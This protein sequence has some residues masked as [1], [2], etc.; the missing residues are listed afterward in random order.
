MGLGSES[1]TRWLARAAEPRQSG[2]TSGVGSETRPR[3]STANDLKAALPAGF[4]GEDGRSPHP[5]PLR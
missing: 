5:W 1:L 4:V 3:R 2:A